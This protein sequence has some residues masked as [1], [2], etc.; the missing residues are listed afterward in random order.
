MVHAHIDELAAQLTAILQQGVSAG[1][2]EIED[3]PATARAVFEATA[4]FHDPV[5]AP[6][7]SHPD[8]QRAFDTL[9]SLVVR[10]ISTH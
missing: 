3:L 6:E 5:Y 4:H 7:W 8:A 1:E 2:F 9:V 10:G